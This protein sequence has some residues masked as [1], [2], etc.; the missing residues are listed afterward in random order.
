MASANNAL[1]VFF[2]LTVVCAARAAPAPGGG[3]K[4]TGGAGESFD[5]TKLGAKSDGK[6]DS[7]KVT[8]HMSPT[9][10]MHRYIITR[11]DYD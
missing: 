4:A 9:T 10:A 1:R 6:T 7:T 8:K 5:I 3:A 11:F 2:I